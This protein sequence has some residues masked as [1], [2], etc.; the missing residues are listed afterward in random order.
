MNIIF[1]VSGSKTSNYTSFTSFETAVC[2]MSFVFISA[3]LLNFWSI[4]LPPFFR[5]QGKNL[6]EKRSGQREERPRRLGSVWK[7]S[8]PNLDDAWHFLAGPARRGM[9]VH[10]SPY[11]NHVWFR[12]ASFPTK[13]QPV[14][15]MYFLFLFFLRNHDETWTNVGCL[16]EGWWW[17]FDFNKAPAYKMV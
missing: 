9:R 14:L 12:L 8:R 5:S 3:K 6:G 11:H 1:R 2:L 4:S 7:L 17:V 16:D 13:G 10:E 15:C